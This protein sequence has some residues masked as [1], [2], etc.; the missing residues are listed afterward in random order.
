MLIVIVF[1]YKNNY[2]QNLI[3]IRIDNFIEKLTK[4]I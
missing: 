2:N 4:K 3:Y 1:Y